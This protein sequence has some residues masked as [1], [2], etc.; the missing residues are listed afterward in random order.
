MTVARPMSLAEWGLLLTLAL[1]WGGSFFFVAVALAE[2]PP[3]T[4]VACRVGV[5]ALALLAVLPLA[6]RRMPRSSSLW[7]GFFVMGVLNN[8]V[9]F[10]LIVSAQTHIDSGL[11]AILNATTPLFTV[12]LAHLLT[13][14]ERLA[15]RPPTP[16][17]GSTGAASVRY[18]RSWPRPAC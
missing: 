15:A 8:I 5:A 2:L 7:A 9:P 17:P 18:R 11:A 1:P 6:G 14:D 16:A 10:T 3:L 4:L 13:A 12:L